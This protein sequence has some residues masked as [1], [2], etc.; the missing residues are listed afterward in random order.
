MKILKKKYFVKYIAVTFNY[1]TS[2]RQAHL[3]KRYSR[4]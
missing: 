2:K 4:R 1:E 3:E